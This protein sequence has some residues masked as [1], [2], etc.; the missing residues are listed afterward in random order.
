[1]SYWTRATGIGSSVATTEPMDGMKLSRKAK[2]PN[3]SARSSPK[4][5][6]I[7]P[8]NRPVVAEIT[9]FVTMNL[10]IF[11]SIWSYS[12]VRRRSGRRPSSRKIT[13]ISTRKPSV[14]RPNAVPAVVWSMRRIGISRIANRTVC[15]P[16]STPERSSTA[17]SRWANASSFSR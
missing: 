11:L 9:D 5:A 2:T 3:T 13:K 8:T 15:C 6:R 16:R 12:R 4:M 14:S 17:N 1:M 7:T 10:R